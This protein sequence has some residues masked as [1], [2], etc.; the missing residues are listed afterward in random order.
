[1]F[2]TKKTDA[3]SEVRRLESLTRRQVT[4]HTNCEVVWHM[5]GAGPPVVLLHG[6]HGSWLHWARNFEMLADRFTVCM[7]DMPGFGES[8]VPTGEGLDALVVDLVDSINELLGDQTDIQLVGFS[9]GGLVAAHAVARRGKVSRLILLGPSGHGG[10]RRINGDLLPWRHFADAGDAARLEEAMR[11]NLALHMLHN[12]NCVD[13]FATLVHSDACLR[14]RFRSRRHSRAGGLWQLLAR[15]Q[16]ALHVAWG[17]HDVTANPAELIARY[18]P[19][20]PPQTFSVI[21]DAGHWVLYENAGEVN[22]FLL[23]CLG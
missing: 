7:P 5:I 19:E 14:A 8:S 4:S 10:N 23:S 20:F 15:Q 22:Q 16:G 18:E 2:P 12:V 11:F 9:F 1:M 6:G 3:H 17:E 21:P 13:D